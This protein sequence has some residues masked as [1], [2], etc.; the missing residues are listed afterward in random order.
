[1][2]TV[3]VLHKLLEDCELYETL[4][5]LCLPELLRITEQPANTTKANNLKVPIGQYLHLSC[6]AIGL[7]PPKY[8][9]YCN[10]I[11]LE[12]STSSDL[13]H[14]INKISNAGEYKCKVY[15]NDSDGNVIASRF[16]SSVFVQIASTPV[17]ILEQPLPYAEVEE[18][19]IL[20]L[21]CK[22]Q[23]YTQLQY[24]WFKDNT[25]LQGAISNELR[26]N[27]FN[28]K[29]EGK[30]YCYVTNDVSEIYTEKSHVVMLLQRQKA[31]AKIALII[32]NA[33]YENHE[34]L[35]TSRNDAA[36]IGNLLKEIG[37]E[38]ICL[39]NVTHVQMK[40]AMKIFCQALSEGMYGLFYFA[41]HG[42]KM[43]ENYM[44]AI[45]APKHYLRKD[46]ICESELLAMI[47]DSDPTLLVVILDMCQTVPPKEFNPDIHQEIPIVNEYKSK[48]N[49]RNLI[50]AY[51][52]S[53][54][55]PSYERTNHKY[56]LYVTHLS[57]YISKDI[58]VAKVF[59]EV[60]RSVDVSLK[61]TERNQIP[62]YASTITKPFRLTDA[63]Y[64]RTPPGGIR[65]LHKLTEFPVANF[66]LF[67]KQAGVQSKVTILPFMEPYINWIKIKLTELENVDISFYNSIHVKR[68]NLYQNPE[69]YE[70]S[71]LNPQTS[72][73]PL[74]VSISKNGSF[75]GATLLDIKPYMP[76]LLEKLEI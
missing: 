38:V 26:I 53:S 33:D 44:L 50:Q 46:A 66:N 42:F 54:H 67:F 2:C 64:N 55:R 11:E 14:L 35:M 51:S 21:K 1:M 60:G 48:K 52:T 61:G 41:G 49:L 29:N 25:K 70:C 28:L 7:P 31:V 32:A 30:Y 5:L 36:K 19:G 10:N 59:E 63:I 24:Q 76:S 69:K 43:Q 9:W 15:Q 45:D 16:S 62:M 65:K 23:S 27:K 74:V 72:Q 18:G 22:A 73:G 6:R 58:P 8:A 13:M 71:V 75:I 17:K 4:S 47:L 12:D 34:C 56:G 39:M 3:E 20:V 57:K 68:N 37:F 40:N